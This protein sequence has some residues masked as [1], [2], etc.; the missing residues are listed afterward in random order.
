MNTQRRKDSSGYVSSE[1]YI[2]VHMPLRVNPVNGCPLLALTVVD[3]S[4]AERL[5]KEGK[6]DQRREEGLFMEHIL[7]PVGVCWVRAGLVCYSSFPLLTALFH[8]VLGS[9]GCVSVAAAAHGADLGPSGW[10]PGVLP[11][12]NCPDTHD[13]WYCGVLCFVSRRCMPLHPPWALLYIL[14]PVEWDMLQSMI[15]EQ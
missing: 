1:L 5:V 10:M 2:R 3:H 14:D 6:V 8:C 15:Q 7:N 4:R 11:H 12:H 9:Y 13:T